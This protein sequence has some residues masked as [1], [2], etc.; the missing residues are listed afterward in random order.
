MS[1][2]VIAYSVFGVYF[3]MEH[4]APYME[5]PSCSHSAEARAGKFCSECGVKVEM[6]K[7]RNETVLDNMAMEPVRFNCTNVAIQKQ[8][9]LEGW[10]I[11]RV[12]K[13]GEYDDGP[14]RITYASFEDRHELASDISKYLMSMG[15]NRSV[16]IG[17]LEAFTYLYYS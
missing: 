13:V 3:S 2:T 14:Q 9:K 5:A 16:G 10:L 17:N 1:A 6:K 11:G 4:I 8:G 15:I 12:F 7:V